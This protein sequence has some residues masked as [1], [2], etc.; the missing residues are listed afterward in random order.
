MA[1]TDF[2]RGVVP[3]GT[4]AKGTRSPIVYVRLCTPC[5]GYAPTTDPGYS[6]ALPGRCQGCGGN[7]RELHKFQALILSAANGGCFCEG[8]RQ[9]SGDLPTE[10]SAMA[11]LTEVKT[12][13]AQFR[14]AEDKNTRQGAE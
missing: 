10:A 8:H 5:A 3:S 4:Y 2:K 9:V 1:E 12:R 13:P 11:V 6:G 7:S 14:S